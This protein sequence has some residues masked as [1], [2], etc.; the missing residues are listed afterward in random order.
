MIGV[1]YN[2]SIIQ[3]HFMLITRRICLCLIFFFVAALTSLVFGIKAEKDPS[4]LRS[5]A[6][7]ITLGVSSLFCLICLLTVC[8]SV[9]LY[10]CLSVCVWLTDRLSVC[11]SVCLVFMS[12]GQSVSVRVYLFVW[13]LCTIDLSVSVCKNWG[14]LS[15]ILVTRHWHC[16]VVNLNWSF[17]F[18]FRIKVATSVCKWQTI[19]WTVKQIP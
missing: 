2:R 17:L 9:C 14:S 10:V 13:Q 6:C 12:V 19:Q 16:L 1:E 5:W 11:R 15:V 3:L 8:L 7:A 4:L 18:H